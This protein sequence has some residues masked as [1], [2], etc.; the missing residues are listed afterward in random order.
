[1][2][3]GDG[4][5]SVETCFVNAPK[6]DSGEYNWRA[7][8]TNLNLTLTEYKGCDS[9][10]RVAT[11]RVLAS[12]LTEIDLQSFEGQSIAYLIGRLDEVDAENEEF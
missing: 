9:S 4:F 10:T 8:V 5:E 3:P 11:R 7:M 2:V 12:A 1:M 6:L